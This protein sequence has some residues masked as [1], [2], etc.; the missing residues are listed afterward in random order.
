MASSILP[1]IVVTM[2]KMNIAM[3]FDIALFYLLSCHAFTCN[4]YDKYTHYNA[5]SETSDIFDVL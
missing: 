4:V 3:V 2:V 5:L 1:V